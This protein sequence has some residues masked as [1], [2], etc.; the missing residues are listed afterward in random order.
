[1]HLR[2]GKFVPLSDLSQDIKLMFYSF[3]L[4]IKLQETTKTGVP[5]LFLSTNKIDLPKISGLGSVPRRPVMMG[6]VIV[7]VIC[8]DTSNYCFVPTKQ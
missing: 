4:N 3:L 7:E 2:R 8:T 6:P 5:H 1:M